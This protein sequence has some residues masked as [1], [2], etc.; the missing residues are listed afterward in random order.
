MALTIGYNGQQY[1]D[2]IPLYLV[3][4]TD[5]W[6]RNRNQSH[7]GWGLKQS[8]L[9]Q[10]TREGYTPGPNEIGVPPEWWALENM[11]DGMYFYPEFGL[12]PGLGSGDLT[13]VSGV[14]Y[15]LRNTVYTGGLGTYVNS[16][17]DTVYNNHNLV[18]HSEDFAN[19]AWS[20]QGV[21]TAN[22]PTVTPETGYQTIRLDCAGTTS[23]D[24]SVINSASIT[25]ETGVDYYHMVR[26]R[27]SRP[28][29]VGKT[30][31]LRGLAGSNYT[32]VTLSGGWSNV[33]FVEPAFSTS[34]VLQMALRGTFTDSDVIDV[35][36]QYAIVRRADLPVGQNKYLMTGASA[37]YAPRSIHHTVAAV[38]DPVPVTVNAWD[39]TWTIENWN[40]D[41]PNAWRTP[42]DQVSAIDLRN[43]NV[44]EVGKEYRFR[45]TLEHNE[46]GVNRP[47]AYLGGSAPWI[48]PETVS[49]QL[50][51]GTYEV[52]R[53]ADATL[54]IFR[55]MAN[56][57]VRVSNI[58]VEE[59]TGYT[60]QTQVTPAGI[61][62]ESEARTN[63]FLNSMTPATQ[64]ITVTAVE[65]SLQFRGFGTI[66]LS[67]AS[68]E[69]PLEGTGEGVVS[70]TFTPTAGSLTLT[71]T[72][73]VREPQLEIGSLPSSYIPTFSAPV[74]RPAETLTVPAANLPAPPVGQ[75]LDVSVQIAGL[76]DRVDGDRYDVMRWNTAAPRIYHYYDANLDNLVVFL[77]D[78]VGTAVSVSPS[79]IGT[80]VA[81]P[82][83]GA[84]ICA[85]GTRTAAC[86]DGGAVDE[87]ATTTT[88][89]GALLGLD[90]QICPVFMGTLSEF[91]MWWGDIGDF[92]LQE[93]TK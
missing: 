73:D 46:T 66:T 13:S 72:G 76:M 27:P 45:F 30:I 6:V 25:S 86:V 67:G 58:S 33:S 21:G 18:T 34:G 12:Q 59:I 49:S 85:S 40:P 4:H 65:H 19:A 16:A 57:D 41:G 53:R 17:G 14:E 38:G 84:G 39:G 52:I 62:L 70:L 79:V 64:S 55:A 74:T 68:T 91:R 81:A 77:E 82:F 37:A 83:N 22:A 54:F 24:Q 75:P 31:G 78:T 35:D 44:T 69:G 5:T 36:V 92:R 50:D 80:G 7:P 87:D 56:T 29:D 23:G 15:L 71:L 63:L 43:D 8:L 51:A 3:D 60:Q 42:G 48:N 28:E 20:K 88:V 90:L 2:D 11:P 61:R 10:W 26:L 89:D 93:E 32:T 9:D 1:D 47:I